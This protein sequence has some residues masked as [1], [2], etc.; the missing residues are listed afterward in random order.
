MTDTKRIAELR[1][2]MQRET[3]AAELDDGI[4]SA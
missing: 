3:V 4:M 1:R 2:I